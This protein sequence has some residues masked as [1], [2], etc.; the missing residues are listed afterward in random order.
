[1]DQRL[2]AAQVA[3]QSLSS[4]IQV[5]IPNALPHSCAKASLYSFISNIQDVRLIGRLAKMLQLR[6]SKY[7][8]LTMDYL[9]DEL[10]LANCLGEN[11]E[12]KERKERRFSQEDNKGGSSHLHLL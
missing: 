5:D 2:S 4:N 3:I 12:W 1:M 9:E 11:P 10:I 6:Q 7:V 8:L